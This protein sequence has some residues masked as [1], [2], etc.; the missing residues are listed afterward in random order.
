MSKTFV[1]LKDIDTSQVVGE[2]RR[3]AYCPTGGYFDNNLRRHFNSKREKRRFL[4]AHGMREA[5]ELYNP[6][7][8]IEGNAGCAVKRRGTPGNFRAR[9]MPTWM[10]QELSKYVG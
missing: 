9:P 3:E 5:G 10:K 1:F 8:A 7:K 4:A 6:E 2:N